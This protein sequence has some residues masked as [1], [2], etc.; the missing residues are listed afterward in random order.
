MRQLLAL[1][2][3]AMVGTITPGPNNTLLLASGLRFGWRATRR[4]V[5]G[6]VLGMAGLIVAVAAGIGTLLDAVP[7]A[8]LALQLVGSAYLLWLALR[9]AVSHGVGR[10][11]VARPFGVWGATGFQFA[12]PKGWLFVLAAVGA[13]LP[14]GWHPVAATA[15]VAGVCTL[16]VALSASVWA[17]GGAA[18]NRLAGDGHKL[19]AVNIVL[20]VVLVASIAFIW[21]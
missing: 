5:I 13:F 7:G 8:R 1:A 10:A 15:A 19:R 18:L 6:T 20:A 11:E 14:P 16:A 12:N 2:G 17:A 3:F 9:I 21:I 4:H